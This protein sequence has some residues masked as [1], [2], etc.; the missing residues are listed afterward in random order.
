VQDITGCLPPADCGQRVV[1]VC[2]GFARIYSLRGTGTE[3]STRVFQK[4]RVTDRRV[5]FVAETEN[6]CLV[7]PTARVRT[8]TVKLPLPPIK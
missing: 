3:L 6:D 4:T 8:S 7:Q 2:A 1:A 5:V